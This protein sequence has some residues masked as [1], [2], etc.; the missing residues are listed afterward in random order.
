MLRFISH[1]SKFPF[2]KEFHNEDELLEFVDQLLMKAETE[3]EDG[4]CLQKEDIV[5]AFGNIKEFIGNYK[6]KNLDFLDYYDKIEV[7]EWVVYFYLKP[8]EVL[9]E[10]DLDIIDEA[11]GGNEIEINYDSYEG[12]LYIK[13]W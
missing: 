8:G 6:K 3:K 7:D 1:L 9:R 2:E 10:A 11:L 4:L 12:K 13:I 5:W